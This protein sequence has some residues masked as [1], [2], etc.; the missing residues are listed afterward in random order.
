[1]QLALR[2]LRQPDAPQAAA[3]IRAAFAAQP[4]VLDPP[5]S[6][7]GVSAEALAAHLARAGGIVAEQADR[8]VGVV[9]WEAAEDELRISRLAVDPAARRLG[10]A[11]A[12]LA[13]AEAVA[14]REGVARLWLGTRLA[15]SGN[16]RLFADCGFVESGVHAHPG[17]AAPTWVEMEKRLD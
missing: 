1:M 15:L 16:R 17:Y 9:L 12:L 13:A 2:S 5:A 4:V 6:A 14:R 11:R 10:I 7:L 3:L 8:M